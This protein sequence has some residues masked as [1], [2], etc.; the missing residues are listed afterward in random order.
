MNVSRSVEVLRRLWADCCRPLV[1]HMDINRTIIQTDPAGGKSLLD[2]LNSNVADEVYGEVIEGA[3]VARM[4]PCEEGR[5]SSPHL[6]SYSDYCEKVNAPKVDLSTLPDDAARLR[7]WKKVSE[8]RRAMLKVFTA[9]GSPGAEY[10]SFVD[11]QHQALQYLTEGGAESGLHEIIPSFFHL[12]NALSESD[13]PFSII[14]RTFGEDGT[15]VLNIW[16]SFLNGTHVVK[17]SGRRLMEW[18]GREVPFGSLYR[19]DNG[20]AVTWER[21]HPVPPP[22]PTVKPDE[23]PA[24]YLQSLEGV[25]DAHRVSF[26]AL[27]AELTQRTSEGCCVLVDYYHHWA[28]HQE[29]RAAGKVFPIEWKRTPNTPFQVFFDDNIFIGDAQSI[30]DMRCARTGEPLAPLTESLENT[31]CCPVRPL[32]AIMDEEYFVKELCKRIVLQTEMTN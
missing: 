30:V 14:F 32:W 12:V 22:P 8:G 25:S 10:R 16:N 7:E 20:M 4:G 3:F 2:V 5:P 17:P 28:K 11:Q 27:A 18:R 9:V 24:L 29:N 23:D 21:R 1:L 19:N 6:V 26:D 13:V 31:F 15:R